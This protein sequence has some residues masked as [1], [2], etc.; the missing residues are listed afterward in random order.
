MEETP[1]LNLPYI[2]AAQAQKHITHNE[3]IRRLDAVV[4]MS[5]G[6]TQS[7]PPPMPIADGQRY[8]VDIAATGDWA[9]QDTKVAAWQDGEWAFITPHA[10][11]LAYDISTGA[12]LSFD[13][14]TWAAMASGSGGGNGGGSGSGSTTGPVTELGINTSADQTNRLAVS[15]EA[16]LF[17]HEGDDQ[18]VTVN[19]ATAADAASLQFQTGYSA[20]GEI[21]TIGNGDLKFKTKVGTSLAEAIS[22]HAD[23]AMV[24]MPL[25]PGFK[26]NMGTGVQVISTSHTVLTFSALEFDRSNNWNSATNA[27]IAPVDGLYVF[28]ASFFT[29][30]NTNL[31]RL[32]FG[33]NGIADAGTVNLFSGVLPVSMT[34]FLSLTAGDAVDVRT[35]DPQ[36]TLEIFGYHCSFSGAKVA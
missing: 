9:G 16:V 24:S 36:G 14:S 31:A 2:A 7:A 4:Q 25:Q 26:L 12:Y 1:N 8:I 18:R 6:A 17:T 5:V 15:S 13:G 30:G 28:S 27:F 22:I 35:G 32:G 29:L 11:W 21:G 33:V 19:R 34:H 23:H 20:D 3:A 10:G